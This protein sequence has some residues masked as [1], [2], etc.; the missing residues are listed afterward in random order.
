MSSQKKSVIRDPV[1]G[2]VHLTQEELS[3]LDT[4]EM[5][6]M[7][8][9]R[10]LGT[11]YL[12]YPGA[13][14]TR[15]EHMIGS[16]HM[17]SRM[18]EAI[19]RNRRLDPTRCIGVSE[20]E[21]RLI[22]I[23]ALLHDATHIPFGHNIEDQTGLFERH[24]TASRVESYLSRG[25]LGERLRGIGVLDQVLA[26]LDAGTE[27]ERVPTYWKQIISDTICADIFDY[28]KRDAYYTGLQLSYDPRLIHAFKID[29]QSGNLFADVEKRGLVREDVLS[30][31]V[32]MLEARYYFS[33]RVYYHHA[34]IAA[35][36]LIAKTVE[37]AI[38]SGAG[39][40][41][42]FHH[43]TD[44]SLVGLLA[45]LDYG[46]EATTSR[47]HRL[48]DRFRSRRLLKRCGVYPRPENEAVQEE[49][50]ERFFSPGQ[51]AERVAT[52][53]RIEERA[54]EQ[55][56]RPVDVMVYCPARRMQ[57][58]EARI[59]V[60][61]PGETDVR[62]LADF[63]DRIPR[64]QDLER[65]YRNLWKVYVLSSESSADA[66]RELQ[67]ILADEMPGATN[68]YRAAT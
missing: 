28:L 55:L 66:I 43:Q 38:V 62:P 24:D 56:G 46:D 50:V 48:I 7:R 45:G 68:V 67:A 47:A 3:L 59:H 35:G 39:Q 31:I 22:R 34:K 19:E 63:A 32:R 8:G 11:A 52:E 26:I 25:R 58:K 30:E 1:H 18:I 6:R 4:P 65:S 15:F 64:L 9:V 42:D 36:A 20:E 12:V 17:A 2:D 29:R 54:S 40:P 14:H 10:Q 60:L 5:Q 41:S 16:C 51:H 23:A 13:N 53:R 37:L 27:R 44:D 33:E 49:L 21:E 57:L 61:F